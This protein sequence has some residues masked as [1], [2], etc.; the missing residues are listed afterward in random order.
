[1]GKSVSQLMAAGEFRKAWFDTNMRGCSEEGSCNFTTIGGILS[2]FSLA[3][4]NDKGIYRK[5]A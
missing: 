4:Y 5:V 1:M 3:V 2:L